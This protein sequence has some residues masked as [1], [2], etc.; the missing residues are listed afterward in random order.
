M[1]ENVYGVWANILTGLSKGESLTK[2]FDPK[3][4]GYP[5]HYKKRFD[6]LVSM[7]YIKEDTHKPTETGLLF[8]QAYQPLRRL[9]RGKDVK[10]YL[11][12][13]EEV[14]D[15]SRSLLQKIKRRVNYDIY[16]IILME[17]RLPKPK[18]R[19]MYKVGA[20][21]KRINKLISTLTNAE[22][23]ELTETGKYQTTDR[24]FEY[25]K[26]YLYFILFAM[27]GTKGN[28]WEILD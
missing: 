6:D 8:I 14:E 2:I 4:R 28:K 22:L 12:P 1:R 21:L 9:L 13:N 15:L 10:E 20:N 7:G 3:G 11:V 26:R 24:G 16:T 23:L 27:G 25:I 19:L 18:T 17:A 5:H